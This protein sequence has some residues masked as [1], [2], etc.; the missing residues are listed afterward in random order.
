MAPPVETVAAPEIVSGSRRVLVAGSGPEGFPQ[1]EDQGYKVI[2]LDIEPSVNPDIVAN[3]TELGDENMH[4][5]SENV[6]KR[7]NAREQ[8]RKKKQEWQAHTTSPQS[9]NVN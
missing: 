9:P 1:W 8:Q 2:R 5:H 7:S 6:T 4:R 3:M